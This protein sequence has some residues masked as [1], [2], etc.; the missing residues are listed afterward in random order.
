[1]S[2]RVITLFSSHS[3]QFQLF[4][5]ASLSARLGQPVL[6]R[7]V[8]T[9]VNVTLDSLVMDLVPAVVP[10]LMNVWRKKMYVWMKTHIVRTA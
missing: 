6:M 3:V 2:S 10:I 9:I 1:M 8:T 4:R 5:K 7:K